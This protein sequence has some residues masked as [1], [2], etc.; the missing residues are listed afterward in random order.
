MNQYKTT[1]IKKTKVYQ[2]NIFDKRSSFTG[3]D[4]LITAITH[5]QINHTGGSHFSACQA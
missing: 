5:N 3:V 1:V 2:K 4:E